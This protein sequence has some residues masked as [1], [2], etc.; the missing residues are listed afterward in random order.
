LSDH[1]RQYKLQILLVRNVIKSG[2]IALI[3]PDDPLLLFIDDNIDLEQLPNLDH[4][5]HIERI[6]GM[7]VIDIRK[8]QVQLMEK[9]CI[10]G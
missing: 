6:I 1:I 10:I 9:V 5:S 3:L 2:I 8:G 4:G 7:P